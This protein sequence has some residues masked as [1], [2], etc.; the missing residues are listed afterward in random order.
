MFGFDPKTKN[1]KETVKNTISTIND[2]DA[3]AVYEVYLK[4]HQIKINGQERTK[5]EGFNDPKVKYP[6]YPDTNPMGLVF[7]SKEEA[8]ECIREMAKLN[9]PFFIKDEN[10][11]VLA[12]SKGDGQLYH[13]KPRPGGKCGPI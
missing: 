10:G 6:N 5:P 2:E 11:R 13:G 4:D 12:H 8:T 9:T 1:K 7:N 3:A